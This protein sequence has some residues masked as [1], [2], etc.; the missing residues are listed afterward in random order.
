MSFFREFKGVKNKEESKIKKNR[1]KENG[2]GQQ[3]NKIYTIRASIIYPFFRR[4][5]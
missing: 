2:A 4:H 1:K 3:E 5:I